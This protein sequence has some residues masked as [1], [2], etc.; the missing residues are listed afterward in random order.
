MLPLR[1]QHGVAASYPR[2]YECW[3]RN[4]KQIPARRASPRPDAPAV[5]VVCDSRPSNATPAYSS[6]RILSASLRDLALAHR[7][8]RVCFCPRLLSALFHSFPTTFAD[9]I[10][11]CRRVLRSSKDTPASTQDLASK[12]GARGPPA[13]AGELG[14]NRPRPLEPKGS[15]ARTWPRSRPRGRRF[16]SPRLQV[17]VLSSAW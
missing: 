7:P 15:R 10:S 13:A 11:S 5:N 9:S 6:L 3:A 4:A 17:D 8:G 14:Q 1:L 12:R 16:R 2:F